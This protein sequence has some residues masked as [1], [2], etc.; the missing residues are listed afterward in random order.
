MTRDHTVDTDA[1]T[2][3]Q[4]TGPRPPERREVVGSVALFFYARRSSSSRVGFWKN[5]IH[6]CIASAEIRKLSG[7]GRAFRCASRRNNSFSGTSR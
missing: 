5:A 6:G 3:N 7:E 2:F 4:P 1:I